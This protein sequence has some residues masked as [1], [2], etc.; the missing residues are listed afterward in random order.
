MKRIIVDGSKF[1]IQPRHINTQGHLFDSFDNYETEISAGYVVKLCQE[2]GGWNPFTLEQIEAS[3]RKSGH[4]GFAFNQLVES[5]KRVLN[6]AAV[7][8]GHAFPVTE[9]MGGGWII[10]GDDDKYYVTDD[11]VGRCFNSS[12]ATDYH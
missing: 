9:P 10:L 1:P 12:P 5:G 7:F 8:A 2:L 6:M 3:Y 11:F 4:T